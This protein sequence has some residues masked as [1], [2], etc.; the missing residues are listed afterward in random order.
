MTVIRSRIRHSGRRHGGK[1]LMS[2]VD[3]EQCIVSSRQRLAKG[4]RRWA[5]GRRL[6]A[7]DR[8]APRREMN[9]RGT[10]SPTIT[11]RGVGSF[12][13][14]PAEKYVEFTMSTTG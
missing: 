10:P 6:A 7:V 3:R 5:I 14:S 2:L 12:F 8:S 1:A 4:H 11:A 13:G 9:A